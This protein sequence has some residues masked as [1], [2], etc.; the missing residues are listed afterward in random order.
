MSKILF[1]LPRNSFGGAERVMIRIVNQMINK[2]LDVSLVFMYGKTKSGY[3][4]NDELNV[5]YITSEKKGFRGFVDRVILLKKY[6][7]EMNVDKIVSFVYITNIISILSSMFTKCKVL[8]SERNDPRNI[9]KTLHKK[10]LRNVMYLFADKIVFQSD[11]AKKYYRYIS[12][13]KKEVIY[14]PGP[15]YTIESSK[16]NNV[17][18]TVGRLTEQKNHIKLIHTLKNFLLESNYI[19]KIYGEGELKNS[20]NTYIKSN[21]L[22]NK[23][24]LCGVNEDILM[25][26]RHHKLF[27]LSSKFEGFPNVLIEA[28]HLNTPFVCFDFSPFCLRGILGD[29]GGYI[30]NQ[31]DEKRFVESV[32]HLLQDEQEFEKK[33]LECDE[34][35]SLFDSRRIIEKWI[36]TITE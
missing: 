31:N 26:V 36:S 15:E 8:I 9:P 2:G 5:E 23:V 13:K 11:E 29:K 33:S 10:A 17:I 6:I 30:V 3:D 32:R 16:S 35:K 7:K 4:I 20:I 28:I 19:L 24:L 12:Y 22:T 1:V 18:Y 34:L 27:V 25:E 14:N 21:G